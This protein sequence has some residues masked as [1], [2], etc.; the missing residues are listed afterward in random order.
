M[1]GHPP[2][3]PGKKGHNCIMDWLRTACHLFESS[4]PTGSVELF[5]HK[6]GSLDRGDISVD[7]ERQ[8]LKEEQGPH[9]E[10]ALAAFYA[11]VAKDHGPEEAGRAAREWIEELENTGSCQLADWRSVTA[12]AARRLA[13]RVVAR[14]SYS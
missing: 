4:R 14:H 9:I 3:D 5:Q 1:E 7:H 8:S 12:R 10:R 13:Q 11:A 2:D 6:A